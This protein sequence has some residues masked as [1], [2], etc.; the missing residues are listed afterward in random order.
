MSGAIP[1][2]LQYAFMAWFSAK[3]QEA[4]SLFIQKDSVSAIYFIKLTFYLHLP[5]YY[6][7]FRRNYLS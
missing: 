1:P 7:L 5:F 2:I 6:E 3:A 4:L